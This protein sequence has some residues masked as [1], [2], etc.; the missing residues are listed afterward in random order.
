[1]SEQL[2]QW[3]GTFGDDYRARNEVD[4]ATRVEWFCKTLGPL[5]IRS[6]LEPGCN[7]GHNLAAI[8]DALGADVELYGVEPNEGARQLALEHADFVW[9]WDV[10]SLPGAEVDLAFTS[11]LLIHV[12]PDRLDDALR[13]LH[14]VS[15]RWLLAIEYFAEQ[16]IEREYRGLSN[17]L[18]ARDYGAHYL[19]LFP[20]L[21]LVEVTDD[22]PGFDGARAWLMEKT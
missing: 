21:R 5:G 17:M 1:M 13:E 2:A 8:R 20:S 14:R 15:A 6:V 22:V 4:P 16:D 3:R 19:R 10:Y 18:W 7:A 11:G 9:P 12:P